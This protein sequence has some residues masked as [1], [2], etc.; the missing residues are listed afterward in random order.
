MS[1]M[2]RSQLRRYVLQ[3]AGAW[4]VRALAGGQPLAAIDAA[5]RSIGDFCF[6]NVPLPSAAVRAPRCSVTARR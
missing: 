6:Q 4:P 3:A 2:Q 1:V 5:S